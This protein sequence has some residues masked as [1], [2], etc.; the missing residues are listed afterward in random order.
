MIEIKPDDIVKD[1]NVNQDI[2]WIKIQT[3]SMKDSDLKVKQI[4][5]S[6][7]VSKALQIAIDKC[8]IEM[9][10]IQSGNADEPSD[11]ADDKMIIFNQILEE[12]YEYLENFERSLNFLLN[13]ENRCKMQV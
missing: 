11:L 10:K 1:W 7:E 9:E 8:D 3:S 2:F 4:L 13:H 12:R 6:M 5:K